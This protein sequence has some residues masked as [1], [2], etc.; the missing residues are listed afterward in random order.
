MLPPSTRPIDN[1]LKYVEARIPLAS[2]YFSFGTL[3]CMI[4]NAIMNI[5]GPIP[6]TILTAMREEGIRG[7]HGILSLQRNMVQVEEKI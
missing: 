4:D 1:P 6:W 5:E 7:L 3:D 2:A